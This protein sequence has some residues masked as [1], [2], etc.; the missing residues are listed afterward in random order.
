MGILMPYEG[1]E[2]VRGRKTSYLKNDIEAKNLFKKIRE[3]ILFFKS[4]LYQ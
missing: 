3:Y 4:Y 1:S 2:G